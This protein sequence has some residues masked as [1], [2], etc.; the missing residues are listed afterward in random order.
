MKRVLLTGATGYVGGRLLSRL[1]ERGVAVRCLARRPAHLR[2]RFPSG[3]EIVRG[4]VL[5]PASLRQ[6]VAGVDAAFYLV[7][8]MGET[9]GFEARE[10]AGAR[11]FAAAAVR[12]GIERVV[13]L[14]G[15][16]DAG[17]NLSPHL[18]SRQHVGRI[19]R[20]SGVPTLELRASIVIGSGSLSFEMIRA[21]TEHL[22]I[23]VT[24]RWVSVLAQPIAIQDLVQYLVQSL[25]VPLP[26][27]RVVEV[28]G[29]DR[30]SYLDLMREYARQRDLRRVMI[31]VPLLTPW[32][33]SLWLGLV[34]P[35]YARV[36]RKLV[37]S[38]RHPTIVT[39]E[40]ATRLFPVRPVG[41]AQAIRQALANEDR[42]YAETRWSDAV[43][44]AGREQEAEPTGGLRLVDS[45]A[46]D[47]AATPDA[48]FRAVSHLGGRNGW[49]AFALLWRARGVI[50]LLAGGVGMRRGRP[51]GRDLRVG[52]ALDFWR[53]EAFEAGRRLRLRA[54]MK[55]P[56][57]AWLEFGVAPAGDGARITQTA[58][59][60]PRGLAGRAYWYA[61]L[62]LHALVFAGT[63]RG[64]AKRARRL[65][66]P[67]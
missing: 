4:D 16:G 1:L 8:A 29:A 10:A 9:D 23:M 35:L 40:D 28:G 55:V 41:A 38:I 30:L 51:S 43:S 66:Q 58:T 42:A 21:L 18:R 32:L 7:H 33:S 50:D 34:T 67:G 37:E 27:S 56:G 11:N 52:D 53:V 15:L 49:P 63:L 12:A 59:F 65:E 57:R 47:V 25:D 36:G 17:Q 24:P 26:A 46:L 54:E 13:Y 22:P 62:P 64:I 6:A 31:Q 44:S 48:C 20:E 19:L 60:D 3:I 2:S 14:G 5:D 39:T 45:R 61:V